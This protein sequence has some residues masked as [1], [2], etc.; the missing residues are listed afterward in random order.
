MTV[1]KFP[2]HGDVNRRIIARDIGTD[3][4]AFFCP[5]CKEVM[6]VTRL[7]QCIGQKHNRRLIINL[8]CEK[9]DYYDARKLFKGLNRLKV[10]PVEKCHHCE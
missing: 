6:T 7:R 9:C 10:I 2:H 8:H 4:F 1:D 3:Y 5:D